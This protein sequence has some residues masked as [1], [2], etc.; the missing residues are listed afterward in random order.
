MRI[1]L[2]S[3]PQKMTMVIKINDNNPSIINDNQLIKGQLPVFPSSGYLRY[4]N[5]VYQ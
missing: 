3:T 4:A 1:Y 5:A 2:W